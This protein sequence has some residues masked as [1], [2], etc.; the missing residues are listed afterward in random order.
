MKKIIITFLIF[1]NLININLFGQNSNTGQSE[2]T[3]KIDYN[4]TAGKLNTM[5]KECIGAGRANEG[6]RADWQ[7]QDHHHDG[8]VRGDPRG[9]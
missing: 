7:Q 1:I 8:A 6:L 2:R 4:K 9:A 5:F 3:I